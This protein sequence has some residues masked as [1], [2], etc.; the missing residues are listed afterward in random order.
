MNK[1]VIEYKD[2]PSQNSLMIIEARTVAEAVL[3]FPYANTIVMVHVI[4]YSKQIGRKVSA[5]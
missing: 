2:L 4:A 1:Y 5:A 3:A